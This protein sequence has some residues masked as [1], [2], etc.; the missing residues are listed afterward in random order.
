MKPT[1]LT[2]VERG[3]LLILMASQEPV[4]QGDFL[5]KH[6]L[7]VRKPHREKLARA[8]LIEVGKEGLA[9]SLTAQGWAWLEAELAAPRP[10]GVLGLGPLY[11]VLG[12]LGQL[13][14]AS[15]TPLETLLQSGIAPA[16]SAPPAPAPSAPAAPAPAPS[17]PP[18]PAPS[19]PA[20]PA[21]ADPGHSWSDVDDPLARALQ[22]IAVFA[23]HAA[24]F[25]DAAKGSFEKEFKRVEGAAALVFQAVRLAAAKR[26]LD[27]DGQP[28][29]ETSYDPVYFH[30]DDIV[31][32]GQAVRI[33]KAPVTRGHGKAK[34]IVQP[35]LVDALLDSK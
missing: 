34:V 27:L 13:A 2:P 3:I 22:D 18:A 23:T 29:A 31:K 17:A 1:A 25:K 33:R 15:D 10:K 9:L 14:R 26:K 11:A 16:P 20:A 5:E 6:G 12:A 35:G 8:G 4:R 32:L 28:G 24:R 19:A 30:S 21:P 7:S